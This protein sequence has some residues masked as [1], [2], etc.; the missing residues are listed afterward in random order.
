MCGGCM[1]LCALDPNC[2]IWKWV[3]AVKRLGRSSTDLQYTIQPVRPTWTVLRSIGPQVLD[4]D[5]LLDRH[6]DNEWSHGQHPFSHESAA[7]T[8]TESTGDI[9][10]NIL[11]LSLLPNVP[12]NDAPMR[13]D[14]CELSIWLWEFIW[15]FNTRRYTP[16]HGFCFKLFLKVGKGL[17]DAM[18][19]QRSLPLVLA[20]LPAL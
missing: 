2:W 12:T 17:I 4:E 20:Y 16:V 11:W 10:T 18:W 9:C 15:G 1:T 3:V 6:S 19:S 5:H 7:L 13:H 14:L 8:K